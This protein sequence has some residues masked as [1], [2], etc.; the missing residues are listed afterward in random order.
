MCVFT[1]GTYA[2]NSILLGWVGSSCGETREKKAA[3]LSIVN[4]SATLS[5]VWTSVRLALLDQ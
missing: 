2:V 3:A 4:V 1:I 5:F